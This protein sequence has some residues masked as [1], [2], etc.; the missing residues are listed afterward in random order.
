MDSEFVP[1]WSALSG[2][3]LG[4]IISF[5]LQSF[6]F[7]K[8]NKRDELKENKEDNHALNLLFFEVLMNTHV[9]ERVHYDCKRKIA[10]RVDVDMVM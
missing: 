2:V 4:G 10:D 9:F 8:Q 1:L 7:Y 5:S 6:L 3:T